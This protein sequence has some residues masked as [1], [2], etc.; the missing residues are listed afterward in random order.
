MTGSVIG[1]SLNFGYP[2]NVSRSQDAIIDNRVVKPTDTINISFGDAASLNPDNSYSKFTTTPT[3]LTTALVLSTAYT[4]LS[5]QALA[6]NMPAGATVTLVSGANTQTT[7]LSAPAA[8]GATTINVQ[9]FTANFAYPIGSNVYASNIASQFAGIAVREVKQSTL[10]G[11]NVAGSYA[12][13]EPC[14]VLSRGTATVVCN[15]G[16]PTAGG[17][18]YIRIIANGS[19][20]AGVV[21]G[22][23]AAADGTNTIQVTGAKW[24]TGKMDANKVAEVTITQRNNP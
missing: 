1:K 8:A 12:P 21:G 23:E 18:V 9:S 5:V 19:I 22:F 2:G 4:S 17:A 6:T 14:D 13:G 16:T 11:T 10:F 20:P 3:T 15:V 7:T 24:T